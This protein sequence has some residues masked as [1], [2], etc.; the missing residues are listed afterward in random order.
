MEGGLWSPVSSF[1]T[2]VSR[3]EARG[4]AMFAFSETNSREAC[5]YRSYQPGGKR[6]SC[7]EGRGGSYG[8]TA[9]E[10]RR[11]CRRRE[12]RSQ[13]WMRVSPSLSWKQTS[14]ISVEKTDELCRESYQVALQS[15]DQMRGNILPYRYKLPARLVPRKSRDELINTFE[16]AVARVVLKHPHLH[17][18]LVGEHTDNPCW[19]RL[20][21]INLQ[22]H[23]EWGIVRGDAGDM[24]KVFQDTTYEQLDTKFHQLPDHARMENQGTPPGGFRLH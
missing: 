17:V 3:E 12:H 11:L 4:L 7:L 1:Q 15:L 5:K 24:Q 19:V 21:S 22:N 9:M 16:R 13:T 6:Y 2:I 23:I 10:T 18:G 20:D 14:W 8:R